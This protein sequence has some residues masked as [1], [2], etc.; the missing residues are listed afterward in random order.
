MTR[1]PVATIPW[2][3]RGRLTFSMRAW[4]VVM[5]RSCRCGLDG[6]GDALIAAAAADVAAHGVVDLALGRVL[7]RGEDGGRL[8]GLPGLAGAALRHVE[9]PPG[10]LHRVHAVRIEAFE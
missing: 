5:S 9:R 1:P 4:S 3:K 6:R 8:H 10:L 2:R 7:G